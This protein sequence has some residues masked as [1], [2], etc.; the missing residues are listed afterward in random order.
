MHTSIY[1]KTDSV[2]PW[3]WGSQTSL[4][5]PVQKLKKRFNWAVYRAW[6]QQPRLSSEKWS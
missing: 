6:T 2:T 5:T 3:L 1:S 4:L